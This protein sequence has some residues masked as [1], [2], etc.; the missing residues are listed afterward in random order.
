MAGFEVATHGRFWVATEGRHGL[1]RHPS[2]RLSRRPGSTRQ[3]IRELISVPYDMPAF[4]ASF[5]PTCRLR[6]RIVPTSLPLSRV[7]HEIH[8]VLE[9]TRQVTWTLCSSTCLLSITGISVTA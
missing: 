3:A 6:M 5:L 9:K 7:P 8:S 4:L 1:N 2:F